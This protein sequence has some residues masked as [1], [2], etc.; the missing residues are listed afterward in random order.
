MSR[1]KKLDGV[2][3]HWTVTLPITGFVTVEVTASSRK[4]A[5]EKAL[6]GPEDGFPDPDEW[7][8]HEEVCSGNVFHGMQNEAYAE[9]GEPVSK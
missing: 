3:R 8:V 7:Q 4:E 5:I 2:K 6:E 9:A 1:S